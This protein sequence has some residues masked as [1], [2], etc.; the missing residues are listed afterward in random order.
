MRPVSDLK[1][2]AR[3][4]M[5]KHNG[6]LISSAVLCGLMLITL[7]MAE[8]AILIMG[9]DFRV[10]DSMQGMIDVL[11]SPRMLL[12]TYGLSLLI[13]MLSQL[14]FTGFKRVCLIVAK[15][16]KPSLSDLFFPFKYNPDK[17]I[18]MSFIVWVGSSI[19]SFTSLF[20]GLRGGLA[21]GRMSGSAFFTEMVLQVV[22]VIILIL[23]NAYLSAGYYI[24]IEDPD[25]PVV[26]IIKES[27]A[28]MRGNVLRLI[29]I[30]L[31]FAGWFLLVLFTYGIALIY[32]APYLY[33]VYGLFYR[34][35]KGELGNGY[36]SEA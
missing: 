34:D 27:A 29:Y 28:L 35:L 5:S 15:D 31:T 7:N 3:R 23:V 6:I 12:I 22:S 32:V 2:I 1:A 16:L 14:V 25:K 30:T 10:I 26:Y 9:V 21:P 13:S 11:A 19:G 20:N 33:T 17:V 18:I 4:R 8:A 24:Y 36:Y